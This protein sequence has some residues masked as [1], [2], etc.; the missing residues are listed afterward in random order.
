[1]TS[2]LMVTRGKKRSKIERSGKH[3]LGIVS[4]Q[5][6]ITFHEAPFHN[7]MSG[8]NCMYV[9][10]FVMKEYKKEIEEAP[11]GTTKFSFEGFV[12]TVGISS[13]QRNRVATAALPGK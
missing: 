2:T 7:K 12:C 10:Y 5:K 1:M 13:K 3:P 8:R 11:P 6:S 4:F 9:R